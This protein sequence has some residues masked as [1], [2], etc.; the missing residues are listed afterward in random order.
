MTVARC[1]GYGV[2]VDSTDT[3]TLQAWLTRHHETSCIPVM[4]GVADARDTAAVAR[5]LSAT[6]DAHQRIV[7]AQASRF[8]D[9]VLGVGLFVAGPHRLKSGEYEE[10]ITAAH[11]AFTSVFTTAAVMP[12]T[13]DM[14]DAAVKRADHHQVAWQTD[15]VIT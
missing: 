14:F 13:G 12:A 4:V 5:A 1:T 9:G 3:A 6:L 8:E 7:G 15:P 2:S 11:T 10:I